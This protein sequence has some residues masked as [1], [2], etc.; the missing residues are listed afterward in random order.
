MQST[1]EVFLPML[2]EQIDRTRNLE[3]YYVTLSYKYGVDVSRISELSGIE[4]DRVRSILLEE[5]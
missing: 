5:A 1:A 2:K 3:R 4:V